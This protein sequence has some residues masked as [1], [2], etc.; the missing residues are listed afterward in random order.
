[1]DFVVLGLA[2]FFVGRPAL[3]VERGAVVVVGLP[4][5]VHRVL[6]LP[7]PVAVELQAGAAVLIL[8]GDLDRRRPTAK[9]SSRFPVKSLIGETSSNTSRMP[10]RRNH[11]KDSRWISTRLGT[12][13]TLGIFA[14]LTR[15]RLPYRATLTSPRPFT[16]RTPICD[17]AAGGGAWKTATGVRSAFVSSRIVRMIL[18]RLRAPAPAPGAHWSRARAGSLA[19]KR[20]APGFA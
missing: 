14:K 4:A 12:S 20:T 1:E 19:T 3:A 8:L 15:L 5:L 13:R 16:V 18:G 17:G 11:L 6:Q 2:G 9:C 7:Q 10:S